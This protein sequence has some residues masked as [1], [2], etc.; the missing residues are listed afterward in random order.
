GGSHA[1]GRDR[2]SVRGT[3]EIGCGRGA[4]AVA[5]RDCGIRCRRF[6]AAKSFRLSDRKTGGAGFVSCG[7]SFEDDRIVWR[8]D[9]VLDRRGP[10]NLFLV[11]VC[12]EAMRV[13]QAVQLAYAN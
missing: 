11:Y 2:Y 12:A 4:R 8:G 9:W 6:G 10:G 7:T 3:H 5:R 1:G 13:A